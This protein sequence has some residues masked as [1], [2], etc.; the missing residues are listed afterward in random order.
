MAEQKIVGVK[1]EGTEHGKIYYFDPQNLD[2]KLNDRV[3]VETSH[4]LAMALIAFE[5]R[6]ID[7]KEL[8]EPLKKVIR[9][10]TP[11]DFDIQKKLKEKEKFAVSEARKLSERLKLDMNIVNAEYAFDES[12]VIINFTSDGRVDFREL[13]KMLAGTLR[14]RIELRQ[15]GIR[16]KAKMLGGIG[17]CGKEVCCKQFLRDF[18]KVNIKMAKN[19]GISL[20]PNNINGLCGRLMC[21]LAYENDQYVELINMMPKLGSTVITQDGKGKVVYNDLLKQIVSVKIF[22]DSDNYSINDYPLAELNLESDDNGN[23]QD[24]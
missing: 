9:K 23:K 21:C 2:L 22:K 20:N 15:V 10:A 8:V 7:E 6:M 11:K 1:F 13:V 19:Q 18:E 3:I 14:T 12:K 16:D 4:G 5:N 24:S 17:P